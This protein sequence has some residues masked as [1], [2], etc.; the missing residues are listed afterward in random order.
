MTDVRLLALVWP[1]LRLPDADTA[2]F[3]PMLDALDDLSPRIEAVDAGV[4]LVDVTGLGPLFGSERRIAARAVALAREVAPL[5]TRAGIGGNRWLAVL[6][7]RLCQSR[8]VPLRILDRSVLDEL[9][10]SL[11]PADPATRQ[12]F[13]LFGLTSFGQLAALPRSAVGAQFGI[14]GERLQQLARG[15]DPRPLVPRRR[16]ERLSAE[17][18]FETPLTD[19]GAA[20]LALRAL[21]TELVDRLRDRHLAPGRAAL[22]LNREDAPPLRI[23]LAFPQ[24][25][26]EPDWIARLLLSRLEAAARQIPSHTNT[27][28]DRR[29]V[30][31]VEPL[32]HGRNIGK[33]MPQDARSSRSEISIPLITNRTGKR[34]KFEAEPD[35][36]PDAEPGMETAEERDEPRITRIGLAFDRLSNP[37]SRQLAAFEPQAGRW[38]EL[39]WSLE[40]VAARFGDGRL[41]RAEHVRPNAARAEERAR[42]RDIGP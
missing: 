26:L 17:R 33:A 27:G 2:P 24:P 23:R 19:V 16:P 42:L 13:G 39:R 10:L 5:T 1:D 21:A 18:T 41:W 22:E 35:A 4:A 28:G 37:Q 6:A 11:L 8:A 12:R 32:S 36:E 20:G 15:N 31:A 25:A 9:P 40:R 38:E 3:E 14:M 29:V 30:M 34:R 7:A